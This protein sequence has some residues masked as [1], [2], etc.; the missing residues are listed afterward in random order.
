MDLIDSKY[1]GLVSARLEKFKRVKDNLYNFRCPLCGD[2]Q[3]HKNKARGYF[4]QVKTNT[5]YKCHNCGA[6]MSFNNFL[7][8]IDGVLHGKYSMEKFKNGF[9]GKN[10][11]AEEP[12]F[13]FEKPVFKTKIDLPL[14]SEVTSARTYLE[15]RALD[16]TL[17]YYAEKFNQFVNTLKVTFDSFS[18]DEPRIVIPLFYENNLVGL[19]GR[20]INPSYVKYITIMLDDDSPKIYGLDNIRRDAPVFVTEGPFDSTFLRNSIAM[21]GADG[22]VR[23]WGVS[24]PIWVYD[25]EP[26]NREIV[27]RISDTIDRGDKVVIWPNDMWEKDINDMVLYGH[28]I[29][30]L[31]ESNTYQGLEA[32]MKFNSWKKI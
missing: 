20:A 26:R 24:D 21:C 11:P 2:S 28:M 30:D 22:D 27:R 8:K 32:K 7:K 12:K 14:C 13:E 16:P 31:L 15:S 23:K 5:N 18:Q 3:K 4:Y 19:Q 25:N 10:F 9:T 17:F 1:I 6:S 29:M